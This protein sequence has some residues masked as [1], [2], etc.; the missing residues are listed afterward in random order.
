VDVVE[1]R[2]KYDQN[3]W[4]ERTFIQDVLQTWQTGFIDFSTKCEIIHKEDLMRLADHERA[5]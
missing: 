1:T 2:F 4:R 5:N 3:A